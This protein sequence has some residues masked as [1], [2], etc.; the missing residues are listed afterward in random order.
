M[1]SEV[2][3]FFRAFADYS[4]KGYAPIY[5]SMVRAAADNDEVI[6]LVA[7]APAEAHVPNNL[8]A[9]ARYLTLTGVDHP[10][11]AV[12]EPGFVIG[13]GEDVGAMFCDLVLACPDEISRLLATR[14]VQT[15]EVNRTSA[16]APL[17][18]LIGRR[19]GSGLA[20]ID[21]GCSAGLNLLLDRYRID[22]GAVALGPA[23]A[24]LHLAAESRGSTP[25]A[26]PADISWRRGVDRNPIDVTDPDEARWLESLVW[27]DHPERLARLRAAIAEVQADPPTLVRADAVAGV[28]AALSAAPPDLHA[29]VL[30]TW[31]V[32]YFDEQLRREFEA[33]IVGADRTTSWLAMEMAGIVPGID[34]PPAPTGEGE[35]S[36]MTL[37]NGGA[38]RPVTRE[39]L[40][41]THPHGAWVDLA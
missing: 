34:V 14:Y 8:H 19:T 6:A 4:L 38:G 29:V 32:F 7:S 5:E 37:V 35:V 25:V 17:L 26:E 2:A 41:F 21:V 1:S 39:F 24:R 28:R 13:S 9:A 23:D 18:N 11:A 33:A 20:L 12:Y 40:G 36:V 15:N 27:P 16:I 31:V 22:L 10:L 3:D 30:T